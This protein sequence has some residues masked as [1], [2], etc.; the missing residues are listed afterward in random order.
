MAHR[1]AQRKRK[2][3][4]LPHLAPQSS[5]FSPAASPSFHLYLQ[6][7]QTERRK[8]PNKRPGRTALPKGTKRREQKEGDAGRPFFPNP[9][10]WPPPPPLPSPRARTTALYAKQSPCS[11]KAGQGVVERQGEPGA[12]V[13]PWSSRCDCSSMRPLNE[14]SACP[15]YC[16]PSGKGDLRS[17]RGPSP[18]PKHT[19]SSKANHAPFPPP[20]NPSP[21]SSHTHSRHHESPVSHAPITKAFPQGLSGNARRRKK[22]AGSPHTESGG[23]GIKVEFIPRR[24]QR[25][26]D[27]ATVARGG[28]HKGVLLPPRSNAR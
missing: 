23:K 12:R 18:L 11:P 10:S 16:P 2:A 8:Q 3:S 13:F 25:T 1:P 9:R 5:P 21:P 28:P 7:K 19:L 27:G 6:G 14:R 20:N 17:L 24:D 22:D 15:G 4:R 26:T